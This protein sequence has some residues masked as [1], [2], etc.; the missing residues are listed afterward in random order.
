MCKCSEDKPPA[1][2]LAG[3]RVVNIRTASNNNSLMGWLAPK[4]SKPDR[5]QWAIRK[6]RSL[7]PHILQK[8]AD[9]RTPLNSDSDNDQDKRLRQ[10]AHVK[11]PIEDA[12]AEA[13]TTEA[14][15]TTAAEFAEQ[16]QQQQQTMMLLFRVTKSVQVLTGRCPGG[17]GGTNQ[18]RKCL[19]G[20]FVVFG[21]N[22]VFCYF[23]FKN[24]G[25]VSK[26]VFL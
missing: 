25:F 9:T 22:S 17:T 10:V 16:Q 20:D 21:S 4:T 12:L 8:V 23:C 24:F 3:L 6:P 26:F 11:L 2:S 5:A 15:A 19:P 13:P 1:P 14:I 7:R 18:R